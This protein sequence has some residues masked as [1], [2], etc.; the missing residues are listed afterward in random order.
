M[1]LLVLADKMESGGAETHI[2]SL[3]KNLL[4]K[5]FD[6]T[7][8]SGG[9]VWADMLR[10]MGVRCIFAPCD[11][12]TPVSVAACLKIIKREMKN[13]DIVHA[14]TRFT[15]AAAWYLRGLS[16]F[17]KI[18]TTAH[19][20]FAKKGLG[21][22]CRWGDATLAVSEDIKAHLVRV[23][24]VDGEKIFLTKNGIDTEIFSP[25]ENE[26]DAIVHVSRIDK[27]RSKTAFMLAEIA[28]RLSKILPDIRIIIAGGG[29]DFSALQEVCRAK[30]AAIGREVII[31][32]GATEKIA[33]ILE[34]AAV[35]VGVSR[36]LLEAMAMKLPSIASGDEGYG[37]IITEESIP[38]L[39]RSNFCARGLREG[40][41][42]TLFSDIIRLYNDK[43]LSEK[44][45]SAG[46]ETVIKRYTAKGFTEDAIKA[47]RMVMG[48]F[49]AL[50]LGYFGFG[51]MGDE[52]SLQIAAEELFGR[53]F[54]K[55]LVLTPEQN[56]SVSSPKV[57]FFNRNSPMAIFSALRQCDVLILPGGN[58]LQ[59][60]TSN[61]SLFYYSSIILAGRVMKKRIYF[62]SSGFGEIK[63]KIASKIT[64]L[65]LNSAYFIGARTT[66]DLAA[67]KSLS[68]TKY[69]RL[70]PDLCFI[71]D[72]PPMPHQKSEESFSFIVSSASTPRGEDLTVIEKYTGLSAKIVIICEKED[73]RKAEKLSLES[74]KRLLSPA[75][76]EEL[77]D[78]IS[79]SRFVI[80]ARLHGAVFSL[81]SGKQVFL[82]CHSPKCR[83]L[84][85]EIEKRSEKMGIP[86]PIRAYYGRNIAK[87][88]GVFIS[89]YDDTIF[90]AGFT[91]GIEP[92]FNP[93]TII[94]AAEETI[95]P[96]KIKKLSKTLGKEAIDVLDGLFG[97]GRD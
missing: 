92:P 32:T 21:R 5:G 17:P 14:H 6:I 54:C 64:A 40:N 30:N 24:G 22:L 50:L 29:D 7:L 42:D 74:E 56:R 86:S 89:D 68:K 96:E 62:L 43:N 44:S 66:L 81:I 33:P 53:G 31:L 58:L 61:R 87:T 73:F 11:K 8:I 85:D 78:I 79:P 15:A 59:N 27:G 34:K 41:P 63:G 72:C 20:P 12:R 84:V 55:I 80:S 93:E 45:R 19:L 91:D 97:F 60:E 49:S 9:G 65:C 18:V 10:Q 75:S 16:K 23:W 71:L 25:K 36:A 2:F 26:G 90:T 67:V 83:A 95:P 88:L 13:C 70:M 82:S 4:A 1:R 69:A 28:E 57:S 51:N 76:K 3:L 94:D 46:Y 38:D 39:E 77:F 48:N 35:F 52:V 47:Y 37:G